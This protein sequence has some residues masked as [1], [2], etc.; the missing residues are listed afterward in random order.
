MTPAEPPT[1]ASLPEG[2]VGAPAYEAVSG[3]M[4][5]LK[6]DM[7]GVLAEL[8][9]C[10]EANQVRVQFSCFYDVIGCGDDMSC[11]SRQCWCKHGVL[12]ELRSCVE[13]N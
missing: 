1:P 7:D 2:A 8:R 6:S 5:P 3:V 11:F 13:A 12:A 4:D 10:V 9:S